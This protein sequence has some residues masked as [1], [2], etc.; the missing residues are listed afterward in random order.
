MREE[1]K[2]REY[3]GEY[4]IFGS[5]IDPEAVRLAQENAARA[6]V[7]E[8]IRFDVCDA[9]AVCVPEGRGILAANPPYGER[10]LDMEEAEKLY[11]QMGRAFGSLKDYSLYI[12]SSNADF[13]KHFGKKASKRRKLYNGMIQCQLY[14]YFTSGNA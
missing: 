14:M 7:S 3:T 5:D 13:E 11:R 8:Y 4:Q 6:G 2:T 12:L 10:I 9:A 1:A